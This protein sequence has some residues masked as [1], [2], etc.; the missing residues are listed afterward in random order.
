M[1]IRGVLGPGCGRPNPSD[2]PIVSKLPVCTGTSSTWSGSSCSRFYISC[3]SLVGEPQGG[4]MSDSHAADH[5]RA[6]TKIY[7]MI[8]G[9]LMVATIAT[10]A[11]SYLDVS[12][13]MAI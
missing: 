3:R 6:H 11:V 13:P 12:V 2:S 9:A 4:T 10:V 5:I 8:F 1:A 7:F